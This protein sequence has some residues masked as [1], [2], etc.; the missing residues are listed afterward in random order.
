MA[1]KKQ[2]P[3]ERKRLSA[4]LSF[5]G[6]RYYVKG[7]SQTELKEKLYQKRKELESAKKDTEN[8]TLNDYYKTFTENRRRK[9]KE[10]TIRNQAFQFSNCAD[11]VIDPQGNTLG[12]YRLQDI[13]PDDIQL[14]QNKLAESDRTTC[15]VNDTINHLRSVF[16]QAVKSRYISSNPC[17]AVSDIKRTE[18][19]ARETIH[20]A[21]TVEETKSFFEAAKDSPYYN[22]F[23]VMIKTGIRIGE[24]GALT[25]FDVNTKSKEL[26]INKTISR[27]ELSNLIISNSPK[28]DAGNR[29]LPIK[30]DV[31]EII[32]DQRRRNM[33]NPYM[34]SDMMEIFRTSE[35]R[36]LNG[37]SLN[38]AI[39]RICKKIGI[40]KFTCHA[41]R[42]TFAT[43][44]I[45]QQPTRYKELSEYL[46][47][48]NTRITLDLYAHSMRN[49]KIETVNAITI[50]I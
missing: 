14:V 26:T 45:E 17:D 42:A 23:A 21:L 48:S 37:D 5:N 44:W 8:P 49:T 24:L 22:H 35:G 38:K 46:G 41:F 3:K 29:I 4:S 11:I 20:R 43:R 15:T 6:K 50:A 34:K 27:D 13:R 9:V 25:N 28:T 18:T 19:P 47:H 36:L 10:N 1:K 2:E 40:E 33:E 12:S 39:A 30:D 16:K 31:V 7:Y 32:K